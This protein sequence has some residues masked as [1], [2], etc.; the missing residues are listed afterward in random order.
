MTPQDVQKNLQDH[1]DHD[2]V[3]FDGLRDEIGKMRNELQFFRQD[4]IKMSE[5]IK[6]QGE[7]LTWM[8]NFFEGLTFTKKAFLAAVLVI[9]GIV[10]LGGGLKTI[11]GWFIPKM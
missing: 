3:R 5:L 4:Q 10:T 11:V 7:Q 2:E 6:K 9:A 1:K 8:I